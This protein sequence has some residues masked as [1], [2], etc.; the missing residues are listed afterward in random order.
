MVD[1]D[2]QYKIQWGGGK[3]TNIRAEMM[4][5]WGM[6]WFTNFLNIH[7]LNIFGDSQSI[8]NHVL[9]KSFIQQTHLQGWLNN[10]NYLMGTFQRISIQHIRR[11]H[12]STIDAMSKI[13]IA[14]PQDGLHIMLA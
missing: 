8:I 13:E 10:I 7:T 4:A 14:A 11:A 2:L 9:G 5:L 1:H 6:L 3:G 12:K